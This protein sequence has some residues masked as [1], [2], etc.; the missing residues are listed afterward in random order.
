[1]LRIEGTP[2]NLKQFRWCV[3][4]PTRQ[5]YWIADDHGYVLTPHG[6]AW[7]REGDHIM[8]GVDGKPYCVTP[9]AF[10]LTQDPEE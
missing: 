5:R 1:M 7:F 4:K 8:L 3:H 10:G 2:Q 9:A 6:K